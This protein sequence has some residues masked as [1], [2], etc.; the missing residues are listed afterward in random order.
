MDILELVTFAVKNYS[1]S[2]IDFL[3]DPIIWILVLII[4]FQYKKTLTIQKS[5]YGKKLKYPIGELMT[6]SILFG[7][8]AGLIGSIIITVMGITFYELSGFMFI[9]V[10]S[11]ILM[12]ISPRYLCL[13]Y[14]GGLWSLIVLI[15]SDLVGKGFISEGNIVFG[16]IYNN[17]KFD[18]TA[19]MAI[20]AVLHLMEAFLIRMDGHRGAL[21]VFI[22]R[23]EKV[24]GAF[25]LQRFWI[26]PAI[27]FAAGSSGI[28]P[29]SSWWPII[30]PKV[31][32]NIINNIMLFYGK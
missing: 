12:L 15:I 6:T 13:S 4:Y 25:I 1:I 28:L 29:F 17:L 2:V 20:I 27:I 10:T 19:L 31:Q 14:S 22:K 23:E 8:I 9:I 16:F 30:K 18:V 26:I 11:L 3:K 7:L 21:P 24:V 5:M 32:G